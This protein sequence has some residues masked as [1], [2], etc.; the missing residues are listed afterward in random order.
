MGRQSLKYS[1]NK[2]VIHILYY[3]AGPGCLIY[4]CKLFCFLYHGCRIYLCLARVAVVF[5]ESYK[6]VIE[7][8][9]YVSFINIIKL[10]DLPDWS[11][12]HCKSKDPVGVTRKFVDCFECFL[13]FC[14]GKSSEV[15]SSSYDSLRS[16]RSRTTRTKL[17]PREGVISHSAARKV[18]REHIFALAPFFARPECENLFCSARI[19]LASFGYACYAGYSYDCSSSS[20]L[21][22]SLLLCAML[23]G[24]LGTV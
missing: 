17:G 5:V 18:R 8:R 22:S 23:S 10:F 1:V 9:S 19:T 6:T 7:R 12:W 16:K 13:W 2:L 4:Y 24:F 3:C 15:R 20:M 11:F 21:W 14:S